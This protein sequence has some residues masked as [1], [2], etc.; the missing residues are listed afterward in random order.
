M[1]STTSVPRT[2]T[3]QPTCIALLLNT[4]TPSSQLSAAPNV[5]VCPCFPP[6][7]VFHSHLREAPSGCRTRGLAKGEHNRSNAVDGAN[8]KRATQQQKYPTNRST[9]INCAALGA[10]VTHG[11]CESHLRSYTHILGLNNRE[12]KTTHAWGQSEQQSNT[13]RHRASFAQ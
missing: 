8:N 12:I 1:I 3:T 11:T 6:F 4:Q 5:C 13:S 10:Q 2:T 9:V 7:F